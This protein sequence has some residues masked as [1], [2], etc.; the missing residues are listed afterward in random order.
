MTIGANIRRAVAPTVAMLLRQFGSTVTLYR[1]TR[2]RSGSTGGESAAGT[3]TAL[4]DA[5]AISAK[6]D[7]R[8]RHASVFKWG[9]DVVVDAQALIAMGPDLT[10]L[11]DEA[12]SMGLRVTVGD[13]VGNRYLI[14]DRREDPIAGTVLLALSTT[15]ESF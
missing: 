3:W 5:T 15:Q 2:T 11:D 1:S 14:V 10:S 13:F 7:E 4:S 9:A 12:S 6:I 8:S